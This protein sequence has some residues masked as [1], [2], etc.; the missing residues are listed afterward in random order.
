MW[1]PFGFRDKDTK[2]LE[3]ELPSELREFF[4]KS[5]PQAQHT[6]VV[7]NATKDAIVNRTLARESKEYSHKFA[8]YKRDELLLKVTGINCAEIQQAVVECYQG[9]SFLSSNHCTDEIRRTTRC[10]DVQKKALRLLRYEDCYN[11]QQCEKMRMMV[12]ILFV[13]KFGQFGEKMTDETEK[14]FEQE[15]GSMF[16]TVWP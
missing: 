15:V 3:K 16:S 14:E 1:W 4:D 10:M 5:N 7:E 6:L 9:W 12:D 2:E 11:K 8:A 13:N